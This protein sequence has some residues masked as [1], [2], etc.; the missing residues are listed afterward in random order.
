ML[1]YVGV[2]G[3]R[4][5]NLLHLQETVDDVATLVAIV[6]TDPAAPIV[7]AAADRDV[8]VAVVDPA[9]FDAA[10]AFDVALARAVIEYTPDVVCFDGMMEVVGTKYLE[11]APP[12]I[13]VHPSLLPAFRGLEV[14]ERVLAAGAVLYIHLRAH[15]TGSKILCRLLVYKKKHS[16]S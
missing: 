5:R 2:A 8:A 6:A 3:N 10:D 1:R 12:T 11:A 4:G 7:D 16:C 9:D 14:H 13:N 15:A